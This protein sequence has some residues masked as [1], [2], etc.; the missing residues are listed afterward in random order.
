M[1][2]RTILITGCSTGIGRALVQAFVAHGDQVLATARRVESIADLQS[3]HC[4]TYALDVN[5][6]A[7]RVALCEQLSQREGR[8]D[9]LVHNAGI[10]AMGPLLELPEAALCGQFET[11][12]LAPVLLTQQVFPLMRDS[13]RPVIVNLG[14]VSGILTT[15]FAG[16]YC[17]SKA[18]LHTISEALRMELAPFGFQVVTVQPGGIQ[19]NFGQAATEGVKGWLTDNS[20]YAAIR[21]SI[22][23]RAGASQV[24]ATPAEDFA[25]ELVSQLN[26]RKLPRETR[27]GHGSRSFPALKKYLPGRRLDQLLVSKFGLD[28]LH[29]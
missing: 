18:A 10:S 23:A 19:S 24:K 3:D 26:R 1:S 25:A 14:S 20:L 29:P 9:M 22:M 17:A 4:Q 16:A 21:E 8:I 15:P 28:K 7:S 11:N 12:V 13:A 27:I 2:K 6:A 5:A